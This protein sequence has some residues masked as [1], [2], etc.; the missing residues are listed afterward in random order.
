MKNNRKFC[1]KCHGKLFCTHTEPEMTAEE[2]TTLIFHALTENKEIGIKTLYRFLMPEYRKKLGGSHGMTSYLNRKAPG[3]LDSI[4]FT[5]I[6]DFKEEDEC[7][8][9]III[10]YKN[11]GVPH[12]LEI[13]MERAFDFIGNRPLIDRYTGEKLELFWRITDIREKDFTRGRRK[14]VFSKI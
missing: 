3:F 11:K 14:I 6:N 9:H 5:L 8:G 4:S 10:E 2:I 13:K 1:K 7:L 12:H